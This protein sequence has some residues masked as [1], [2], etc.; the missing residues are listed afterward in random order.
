MGKCG[1]WSPVT[2]IHHSPSM[3]SP[4]AETLP[5][6][7]HSLG[8]LFLS[9]NVSRVRGHECSGSELVRFLKVI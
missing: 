5:P 9:I 1:G 2:L 3:S 4:P 7:T 8:H 6:V